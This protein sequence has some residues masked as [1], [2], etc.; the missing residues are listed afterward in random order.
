MESV[1][2]KTLDSDEISKH[3]KFM[4]EAIFEAGLCVQSD[5]VPIGAVVVFE[6][7]I[8]GRGHNE[9]EKRNSPIWHA[10]AIAVEEAA[11]NLGVWNLSGAVLYVTK[12]PCVM[13]A[14]LIVQSRITECV[15]GAS[16]AKGGGCGGAMQI[17]NN[18]ILNHRA[19]LIYGLK[20]EQ[21][22]KLLRDFFQKKRKIIS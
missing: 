19:R 1:D 4:E 10:E 12:E 9:R 14:G 18:E 5:D 22:Q 13:C 20:E 11:G 16:D 21:C 7:R 17:A 6:N 3:S 8:V 15:F 2:I